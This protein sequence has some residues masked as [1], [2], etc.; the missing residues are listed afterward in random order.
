MNA[1]DHAKHEVPQADMSKNSLHTRNRSSSSFG[2]AA[3]RTQV[4]HLNSESEESEEDADDDPAPRKASKTPESSGPT[5]QVDTKFA[6]SSQRPQEGDTPPASPPK[7]TIPNIFNPPEDEMI[8]TYKV[9]R[10]IERG[11]EVTESIVLKAFLNLQEANL[12]AQD[13]YSRLM[14]GNIRHVAKDE[15]FDEN[16]LYLGI[17]I[18]DKN[19]DYSERVW[20]TR[21][22]IYMGEIANFQRR[23]L[24][25]L[26][27]QRVFSVV[28]LMTDES[29]DTDCRV[30]ATTSIKD[31]ANKK[32]ADQFLDLSRPISTVSEQN[33]RYTKEFVQDVRD[34]VALADDK[35]EMVEAMD[36]TN[37]DTG[38]NFRVLVCESSVTGPP[39]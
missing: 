22:I 37:T 2:E 21:E 3:A 32:A 29:D 8:H 19:E 30:V 25:T 28:Q 35:D 12:F 5:S 11:D 6:N 39:N 24:K 36:G 16:G 10:C 33:A 23:E 14:W 38:R 20:V 26:V 18:I 9:R 31:L 17:A 15:T 34:K 27:P 13:A 4:Q 1:D 7:K